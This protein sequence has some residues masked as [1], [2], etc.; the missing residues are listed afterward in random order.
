VLN[1]I[2]WWINFIGLGLVFT[3]IGSTY[4]F[5][6]AVRE[7]AG[8]WFHIRS[9]DNLQEELRGRLADIETR[10]VHSFRGF[11]ILSLGI[12]LQIISF[13]MQYPR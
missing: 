4:M 5:A 10:N 12:I 8:N 6:G 7:Q 2:E 3:L 1:V 9:F 11:A 13:A